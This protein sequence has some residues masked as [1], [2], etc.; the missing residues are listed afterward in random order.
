MSVTDL[1]AGAAFAVLGFALG[2]IARRPRL[3]IAAAGS[4]SISVPGRDVMAT[5]V[6]LYNKPAFLGFSVDR[7][8]A[9]IIA[10]NVVDIELNEAVGPILSWAVPGEHNLRKDCIISSGRQGT[11]FLFGKER[12]AK[13]YFVFDAQRL[14]AP[15][16]NLPIVYGESRKTFLLRLYDVNERVYSYELTVRNLPESVSINVHSGTLRTRLRHLK[17]AFGRLT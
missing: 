6:D 4:H 13:E 1:I 2:L 8:A 10:A 16:P 15:L 3:R 12:Y 14:D 9:T 7:E 17:S 5:S 11:V